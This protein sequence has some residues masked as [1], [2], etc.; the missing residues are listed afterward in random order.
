MHIN[1]TF[2]VHKKKYF[3]LSVVAYCRWRIL[4]TQRHRLEIIISAYEWRRKKKKVTQQWELKSIGGAHTHDTEA[5]VEKLCEAAAIERCVSLLWSPLTKFPMP[6][7][8]AYRKYFAVELCCQ[9]LAQFYSC[10][11][12]LCLGYCSF[13]ALNATFGLS[14]FREMLFVFVGIFFLSISPFLCPSVCCHL[15]IHLS[16]LFS[17]LW[18]HAAY[19][20]R[21]L[22][23]WLFSELCS[24]VCINRNVGNWEE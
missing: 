21:I 19:V 17:S 18:A 22:W 5:E 8:G 2:Q 15:F 11:F 14:C 6:K 3:V 13:L 7:C 20:E 23:R 12:M 24:V 10:F 16:K 9:W 4:S 1:G